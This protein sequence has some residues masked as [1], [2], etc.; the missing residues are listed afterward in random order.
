VKKALVTV[1]LGLFVLSGCTTLIHK[2]R[3][4]PIQP[5]PTRTTLGS[6]LDD[7]QI[8]TGVGVNIKKAHPELDTARINVHAF[9]AVVLLTGEVAREELRGMAGDTAR[10]FRGVR[11]VHNEIQVQSGASLMSRASDSW[12][13]TKVKSRL[14]A[15]KDIDSGKIKVVTDNGV[16]YLMGLVYPEQGNKAANVASTTK[17]VRQVVKVFEYPEAP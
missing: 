4:E 9:N 11:Q 5:D 12:I 8:E 2:V 13:T 17:G 1:L 3:D 6:N 16:V 7:F 14:I 10:R 15:Y